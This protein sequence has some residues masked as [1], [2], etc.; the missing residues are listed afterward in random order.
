MNIGAQMAIPDH[1]PRDRIV[2]VDIYAPPGFEQD[3][4]RAWAK[5]QAE[6]PAL[7]WTPRNEGHWIAL[8]GDVLSEVQSNWEKF[9]SRVII[10]PK[11]IGEGHALIPTTI[12][13]PD[14]RPYRK[15][16][17]DN[18]KPAAVRGLHDRIR[19]AAA[20]LIDGFYHRGTC[21]FTEEYARILPIRIFMSLVDLPEGDTDKIVLW[22]E[23]MTRPEPVMPFD[24]AR[25]AFF[26][27][28]DPIIA[29]RREQPGD[30]MISNML[31]GGLDG[32]TLSHEEA[33]AL[34]TQ[35]LIAGMDTVVNFLG[36]V[37]AE[38]ARNPAARK[39]IAV[40]PGGILAGTNELFRRFGLVTIAR[41]VRHDMQFCGV[42]LKAGDMVCIPT[43]VHGIDAK[44]NAE[45]LEVNFDRARA[46]H[47][48]FGSGPHMC[49]GQE[50]ARS[51]VA[52]TLEEWLRRIPDFEITEDSDLSCRPG[53][54]GSL[55]RVCLKWEVK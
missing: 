12:D 24:A 31:K 16:L 5:L 13:P 38:M 34:C 21:N 7:V 49:P 33:L 20:T 45:P 51:E 8:S 9:S 18:L 1:I 4:H 19:S 55:A 41:E 30:D 36:F 40:K 47:S 52:I 28:L 44:I 6:N 48:A 10:L 37:M 32:R 35:V 46:P 3:Y 2:D 53:I 11:S 14:H 26:D 43:A 25:Q 54:V 39:A 27:Y 22:A 17:N 15:L 50:L 29:Q 42:D 23:C